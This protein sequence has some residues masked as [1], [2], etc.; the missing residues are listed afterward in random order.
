M[1]DISSALQAFSV[2]KVNLCYMVFWQCK[3]PPEQPKYTSTDQATANIKLWPDSPTSKN[4]AAT[5][6]YEHVAMTNT[7]AINTEYTGQHHYNTIVGSHD[8]T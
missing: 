7:L 4:K 5:E 2:G 1:S 8:D 6:I 3:I